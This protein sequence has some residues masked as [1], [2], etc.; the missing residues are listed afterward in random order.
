MTTKSK[1]ALVF[2]SAA[3]PIAA[4]AVFLALA[5]TPAFA[6]ES[7]ECVYEGE[8]YSQGACVSSVCGSGSGQKCNSGTWSSC[9]GC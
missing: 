2:S 5:P 9:T 3:L 8:C 4:M 1:S 7:G 6:C